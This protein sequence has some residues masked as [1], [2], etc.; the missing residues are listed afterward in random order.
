MRVLVTRAEGQADEVASALRDRGAL[1][2]VVPMISLA[3]PEEPEVL[4]ELDRALA[5]LADYDGIVFGSG[6]AVRYFAERAREI[7]AELSAIRGRVFCVGRKTAEA[8]TEAGLTV[9]R[10]ASG[11]GDAEALLAELLED[12]APAGLRFLVPKSDLG[13]TVIPDGLSAAGAEVDVVQA[14]CNIRPEVDAELLC[15]ELVEGSLP[16]LTFMSPSVVHHFADLLTAPAREAVSRAIVVA[17]GSTTAAALREVGMEPDV[18]PTRPEVG[19]LV[20]AL[21]D[22]VEAGGRTGTGRTR[23]GET[24]DTRGQGDES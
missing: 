15:R 20:A 14:Y 11:R 12:A 23:V 4:A 13:R 1:P 18:I 5:R 8:A 24:R 7:G 21:G 2:V 3:P 19:E 22:Y 16:A 17:V 9:H 10:I 6:N